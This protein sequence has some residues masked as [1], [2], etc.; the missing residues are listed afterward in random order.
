MKESGVFL[1]P[2]FTTFSPDPDSTVYW[3][4]WY[5]I[6]NSGKSCKPWNGMQ[7]CYCQRKIG[8]LILKLSSVSL[9]PIT[10]FCKLPLT[11]TLV[12]LYSHLKTNPNTILMLCRFL[13][14]GVALHEQRWVHPWPQS[15]ISLLIARKKCEKKSTGVVPLMF[16]WPYRGRSLHM[17]WQH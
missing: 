9:H 5:F 12:Q 6:Q 2:I 17:I 15:P 14:S 8:Y 4:L 10:V 3:W 16:P 7:H 1:R 11:S 13:S